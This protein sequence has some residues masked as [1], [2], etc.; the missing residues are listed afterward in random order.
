MHVYQMRIIDIWALLYFIYIY[1]LI[2]IY[3]DIYIFIY[4][5]I[6]IVYFLFSYFWGFTL[7][8]V[9]TILDD[10]MINTFV[11]ITLMNILIKCGC[12]PSE[13]GTC[14]LFSIL[15]DFILL[16]QVGPGPRAWLTKII[17]SSGVQQPKFDLQIY[18]LF[19]V[20]L[21]QAISPRWMLIFKSVRWVY[22]LYF[23]IAV[24]KLRKPDLFWL[25]YWPATIPS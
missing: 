16:M 6:F 13:V 14:E 19:A 17:I 18:N 15:L 22:K 24:T 1:I 7:F 2:Y 4:I 12:V 3:I 5:D 20:L 25:S 11:F 21:G 9:F 23:F 10:I 8:I